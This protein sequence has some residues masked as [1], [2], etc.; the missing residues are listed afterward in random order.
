MSYQQ[1]C[2]IATML[3]ERGLALRPLHLWLGHA[4]LDCYVSPYARD[5]RLQLWQ[6]GKH[7]A[8]LFDHH[9]QHILQHK[10]PPAED[11]VL[12][13]I[14]THVLD[15]QLLQEKSHAD[16]TVG[17]YAYPHLQTISIDTARLDSNA[18]DKRLQGSTPA[19]PYPVLLHLAHAEANSI[20]HHLQQLLPRAVASITEAKHDVSTKINYLRQCLFA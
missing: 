15:A 4:S 8:A 9:T 18:W 19:A 14:M 10:Y 3:L 7:H 1:A 13:S 11:D 16:R 12:Y 20:A 17:I 6:W 2:D 5:L